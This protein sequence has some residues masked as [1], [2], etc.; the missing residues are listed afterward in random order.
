[1]YI[2]KRPASVGAVDFEKEGFIKR[3][4]TIYKLIESGVSYLLIDTEKGTDSPLAYPKPTQQPVK[5]SVT[6]EAEQRTAGKVYKQTL[7]QIHRVM[8]N[9]KLGKRIDIAP[10]EEVATKIC[11]SVSRNPFALL[12]LTELRKNSDSVFEHCINSSILMGIFSRHLGYS[13]EEVTN[14]ITGALLHD[15]GEAKVPSKLL[16]KRDKLTEDETIELQKHIIYGHSILTEADN[17]HSTIVD[18]CG[19]H[20]EEMDGSGYPVKLTRKDININGRL[21]AIV[22]TYDAMTSHRLHR[23]SLTP[24]IAMAKLMECRETKL[25]AALTEEFVKCF[26]IYPTGSLVELSNGRIGVVITPSSSDPEKPYIRV[27]FNARQRCYVS[28]EEI[29]LATNRNNL[30]IVRTLHPKEFNIDLNNFL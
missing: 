7:F 19:Q 27:F 6:L 8:S 4:S 2:C 24:C 12:C 10:I 18:M 22:D 21:M 13:E 28:T 15:I 30:H 26:G 1:M 25:D 9:A 20:H 29:D 14:K 3:K 16:N 5:H 23:D 17:S 11:H